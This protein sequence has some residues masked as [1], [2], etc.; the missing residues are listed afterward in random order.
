MVSADIT[1]TS[2]RV[3]VEK[4]LPLCSGR[5]NSSIQCIIIDDIGNLIYEREIGFDGSSAAFFGRQRNS[6]LHIVLSDLSA[7]L[8][9]KRQCADRFVLLSDTKRFHSVSQ[10]VL[11]YHLGLGCI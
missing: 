5:E 11:G 3:F 4:A 2:L 10:S 7:D 8:I 1:L 9:T 6:W